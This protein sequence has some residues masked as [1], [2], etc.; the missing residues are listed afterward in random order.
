[1]GLRCMISR[2][3][4]VDVMKGHDCVIGSHTGLRMM[5]FGAGRHG[6]W[7]DR[8]MTGTV[9]PLVC[10]LTLAGYFRYTRRKN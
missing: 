2:T 8:I 7:R 5:M 4:D 6:G 1:M 10:L 9:H 3:P